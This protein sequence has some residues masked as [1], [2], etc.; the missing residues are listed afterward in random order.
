MAK[1]PEASRVDYSAK[2]KSQGLR[3]VP[4]PD[5]HIIDPSHV[6][7]DKVAECIE[8]SKGVLQRRIQ[9]HQKRLLSSLGAAWNINQSHVD[10][11]YFLQCARSETCDGFE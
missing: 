1:T 10:G 9:S 4:D 11:P 5:R 2:V 7:E 3:L 8:H 6:V